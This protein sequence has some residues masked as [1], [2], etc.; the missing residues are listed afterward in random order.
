MPLGIAEDRERVV[1]HYRGRARRHTRYGGR[2]S[3]R[4]GR[5]RPYPRSV[6][7]EECLTALETRT[8]MY[9]PFPYYPSAVGLLVGFDLAQPEP[10]LRRFSE[11][12]SARHG[13]S[14]LWFASLALADYTGRNDAH[15]YYRFME[16]DSD[17]Q[18]LA[19]RHLCGRLR[20]YLASDRV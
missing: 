6:T 7:W 2:P 1:T 5:Q 18:V 8:G 9:V 3:S 10:V 4:F 12:M 17:E 14:N 16:V 15:E 20:Q 13:G 19:V 11:W